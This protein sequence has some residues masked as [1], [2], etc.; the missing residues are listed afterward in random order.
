MGRMYARHQCFRSVYT[1]VH[2]SMPACVYRFVHAHTFEHRSYRGCARA[3]TAQQVMMKVHA[4]CCCFFFLTRACKCAGD[5]ARS[6]RLHVPSVALDKVLKPTVHRACRASLKPYRV[7]AK[8]F[9]RAS[10][11][12][13]SRGGARR[14]RRC[15]PTR[16][17]P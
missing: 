3:V 7:G 12:R 6:K 14:M 9:R 10:L 4:C 2:T 11:E 5:M 13:R 15:A 16:S 17:N 8:A 1:Y